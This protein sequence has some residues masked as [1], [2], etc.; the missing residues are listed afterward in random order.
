MKKYLNGTILETLE[1]VKSLKTKIPTIGLPDCF[2]Q[3]A[4]NCTND[5]DN[6]IHVLDE[7]NN[8]PKYQVESN[9]RRKLIDF[10]DVVRYID[11]LENKIIAPLS[12]WD[13]DDVKITKF[14]QKVCNE[15]KYPL[16]SPVAS[17]LSQEYYCI[18][19]KFNHLRVPLLESEFL[20]HMPDLYHELAHPIIAMT[21]DPRVS[22]FQNCL[23]Q[24]I[25]YTENYFK[26]E[27]TTYRKNNGEEEAHYLDLFNQSWVNWGIELFCDLFATYTLGSAYA[28]ANLHLCVKRGYDPFHTPSFKPSSHPADDARMQVILNGLDLIDFTAE[29]N[30]I[31]DYWQKF[32][33]INN[34]SVT[35]N[36][37]MA[38]PNHLLEHCAALALDA[39]KSIKC[40]IA[41][42][43]LTNDVYLLLN[44]AWVKF[45]DDP[46]DYLNWERKRRE[47][48]EVK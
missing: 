22:K 42:P 27:I 24:F 1:R 30:T 37:K 45:I 19:T 18:D 10:Q 25:S 14:V 4:A 13:N 26:D 8:N 3:L 31:R 43:E 5:I 11:Y 21:N 44:T 28:W 12:R 48:Y 47:E 20:L 7:F 41:K 34:S 17:R 36:F 23:G 2:H 29:A 9:Q 6:V 35:A 46:I 38:F 15:I 16:L 32:I 40:E 39:T 33:V